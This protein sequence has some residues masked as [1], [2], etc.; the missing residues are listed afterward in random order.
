MVDV[1]CECIDL[2]DWC[3]MYSGVNV[4]THMQTHMHMQM[5]MCSNFDLKCLFDP[6]SGSTVCIQHGIYGLLSY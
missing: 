2:S 5:H 1:L 3:G 4:Q 6:C